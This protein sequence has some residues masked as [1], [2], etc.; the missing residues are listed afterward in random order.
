MG[1]KRLTYYQPPFLF[2]VNRPNYLSPS[3]PRDLIP[4][5]VN[6]SGIMRFNSLRFNSQSTD[7]RSRQ[8]L[9]SLCMFSQNIHV[10]VLVVLGGWFWHGLCRPQN[11]L[12]EKLFQRV[13]EMLQKSN[14]FLFFFLKYIWGHLICSVSNLSNRWWQLVEIYFL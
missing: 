14:F 2:Q 12:K 10:I 7:W 13:T 9:S 8:M 1:S 5:E 11:W 3:E 4:L 6:R